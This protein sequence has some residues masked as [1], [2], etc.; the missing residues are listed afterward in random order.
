ME[1]RGGRRSAYVKLPCH[2]IHIEPGRVSQG[3]KQDVRNPGKC[4][5]TQLH[6][7]RTNAAKAGGS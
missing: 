4:L 6:D 1:I 5:K 2:L 3:L 7:W